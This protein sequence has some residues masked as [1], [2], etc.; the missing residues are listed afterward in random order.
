MQQLENLLL[1]AASLRQK[2][3][4]DTPHKDL[5]VEILAELV[6]ECIR[7]GGIP[8]YFEVCTRYTNQI[9]EVTFELFDLLEDLNIEI[10]AVFNFKD[11]TSSTTVF[12]IV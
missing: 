9:F 4:T 3:D 8:K 6:A 12:S 2:Y 5:K 11:Q 10:G 7:V 1:A